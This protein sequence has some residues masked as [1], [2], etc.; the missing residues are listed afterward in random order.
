MHH[1]SLSAQAKDGAETRGPGTVRS[2]VVSSGRR[3]QVDWYEAYADIAGERENAHVFCIRSMASGGAFH[4][5]FPHASRQAFLETHERAIAYFGGVFEKIRYDN[6]RSAVKRILQGHQREEIVRFIA[7][8]S[9]WDFGIGI[10]HSGRGPRERRRGRRRRQ[11]QKIARALESAGC[12]VVTTD[13]SEAKHEGKGGPRQPREP[14]RGGTR[15][16][17]A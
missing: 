11:Q 1:S 3:S 8:R 4:C 14:Q 6:L 5:A 15:L 9:H 10:L 17:S 13:V 16:S 7:L 12:H 2:A